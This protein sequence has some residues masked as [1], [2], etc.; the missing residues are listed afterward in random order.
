VFR[1]LEPELRKICGDALF[2]MIAE[3]LDDRLA[4]GPVPVVH[5]SE[6]PVVLGRTRSVR[7]A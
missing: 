7:S 3:Y 1:S 4:S 2:E 5:P 6:V